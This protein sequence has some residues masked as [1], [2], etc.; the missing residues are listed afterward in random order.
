MNRQYDFMKALHLTKGHLLQT[1]VAFYPVA[2]KSIA[3][4]M[5]NVRSLRLKLN[6]QFSQEQEQF[7]VLSMM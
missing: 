3:A 7:C 5:S 1:R 4:L 6:Y 2:S